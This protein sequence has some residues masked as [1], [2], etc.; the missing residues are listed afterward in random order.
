MRAIRVHTPGGPEA[1]V[2]ETLPRPEPAAGE[3]R[4]A[5]TRNGGNMADPGSVSYLFSRKGVVTLDKNSLSE[6]DVLLAL[7]IA[8]IDCDAFYAAVEKRDDPSLRGRP[9][10]IGHAGGR[11]VVTTACYIARRFGP[12][13]AMPMFQALRLCPHAVVIP[14]D[15][16][17]YRRASEQIRRIMLAATPAIEPLSLDEAYLDLG[18]DVVEPLMVMVRDEPD[19]YG[20]IIRIFEKLGAKRM[21]PLSRLLKHPDRDVRM[22]AAESLGHTKSEGAIRPLIVATAPPAPAPAPRPPPRCRRAPRRRSPAPVPATA[23][24]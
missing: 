10:L 19:I 12:R 15:M 11:G 6:D 13:S 20:W 21:R 4:V 24:W 22:R 9:L 17:K 5:M 2:L 23:S 16:A 7:T 3:V 14:P 8:H 18:E 1:L